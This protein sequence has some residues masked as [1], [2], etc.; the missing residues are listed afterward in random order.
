M[1]DVCE[2]VCVVDVGQSDEDAP[3]ECQSPRLIGMGKRWCLL[4]LATPYR[5]ILE[6][7]SAASLL[8]RTS[9]SFPIFLRVYDSLCPLPLLVPISGSLVNDTF[10]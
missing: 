4:G 2:T 9:Q 6:A 8:L 10:N 5:M 7:L 3:S 1:E